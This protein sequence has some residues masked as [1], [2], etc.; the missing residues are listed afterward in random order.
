VDFEENFGPWSEPVAVKS[1]SEPKP[2]Q[3]SP[4]EQ[5]RL[6]Y[7]QHVKEVHAKGAGK[8]DKLHVSMYGDSLTGA[9]VYPQC[10]LAAFLNTTVDA[11]GYAGMQTGFGKNLA[12]KTIKDEN[13]EF[14]CVLYGTN[15]SKDPTKAI[16]A[17]MEDL[18]AIVKTCEDN[19]TVAILGTI[20][21]RGFA[22]PESKG[23]AAY[24]QNVIELCHKLQ[25]PAAYIFE[26]VQ[27]AGDRKKF[28]AGDG[29]HW[30]GDGME[31]AG[32]T[33]GRTLAQIRFLLRDQP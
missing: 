25:I 10:A 16:P 1:R 31:V 15:N 7:A 30:T 5:D 4:E 20:P 33:W 29:V 22:D 23:E 11:F 19:G 8:V 26:S 2:R 32:K 13:P 18:A 14:I 28:I 6:I 17:A 27:A 9:T 12:A 24:N 21:P 3:L